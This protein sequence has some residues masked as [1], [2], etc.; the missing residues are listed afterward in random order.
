MSSIF[1]IAFLCSSLGLALFLVFAIFRYIYKE[2]YRG[3]YIES[4]NKL[5]EANR[6]RF[7]KSERLTVNLF[8]VALWLFPFY[9]I[10]IPLAIYFYLR[11]IFL[12]TSVSM[13][14]LVATFWEEY[15]FRKWLMNH[16]ESRE[17]S[18]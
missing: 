9:L 15:F 11:D 12:I 7:I 1:S 6:E 4:I 3:K 5:P 13:V 16:L 8:R 2:K 18:K 17:I 10:F 14:L